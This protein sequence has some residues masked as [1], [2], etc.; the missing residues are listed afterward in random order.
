MNILS[1]FE[2]AAAAISTL[3]AA[4]VPIPPALTTTLTKATTVVSTV[5]NIAANPPHNALAVVS[6]IAAVAAAI[7]TNTGMAGADSSIAKIIGELQTY[8][9]WRKN[10]ESGQVG[11]DFSAPYSVNGVEK[12][13]ITVSFLEGG[14]AAQS[15][16]L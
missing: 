2:E 10:I 1:I 6:D 5:Q 9:T 15:L 11:V 7:P 16:G 8:E 3:A 12:K 13:L 4:G 14:T